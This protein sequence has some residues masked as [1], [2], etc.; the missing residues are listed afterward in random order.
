MI[1]VFVK[2]IRDS[3]EKVHSRV[4]ID[5]GMR[6]HRDDDI[7]QGFTMAFEV[8]AAVRTQLEIYVEP[9]VKIAARALKRL[10][11]LSCF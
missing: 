2:N 9:V 7:Q 1:V 11:I 4:L 10:G 8:F 5:D 6:I 3:L